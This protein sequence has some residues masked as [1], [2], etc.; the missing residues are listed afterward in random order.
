MRRR[1]QLYSG[2]LA[3]AAVALAVWMAA[4]CA[5]L[6]AE[7]VPQ[8]AYQ[9]ALD[10]MMRGYVYDMDCSELLSHTEQYLQQEG[11][12]EVETVGAE[13]LR[14]GWSEPDEGDGQRSRHEV[15][16]HRVEDG[17]CALQLI[18]YRGIGSDARHYRDVPRE[19]ELLEW[20]DES[21][22]DRIR[23]RARERVR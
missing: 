12:P 8:G 4:G 17:V 6:G 2:L 3:T 18:H 15:R 20:I 7:R 13:A 14:T 5:Q 22:A 10:Q 21:E 11:Y 9:T 16:V 19:L 1:H 23:D